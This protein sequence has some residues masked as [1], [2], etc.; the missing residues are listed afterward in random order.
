MSELRRDPVTGG[1]VI[2][3]PERARR[4]VAGRDTF[5]LGAG[6]ADPFAEGN[7]STTPPELFAFREP[8]TMADRPGW[9]VRIVPNK[10][11]AVRADEAPLSGEDDFYTSMTA[12]G[13]HEVIIECPDGKT[14]MAELSEVAIH[15]VLRA[16]RERL[17]AL[18]EDPHI[19]HGLIFKNSGAPAGASLPHSHSQLIA[20]S[21]VP[22][23]L[24]RELSRAQAYYS[25]HGESIYETII[26]REL[27]DEVRVVFDSPE[28][29]VFCPFA[30]RFPYETWI[31]PKRA[32]SHYE[33]CEQSELAKLA[34]VLKSV[35]V[36]LRHGL[37]DPPYNYILHTAPFNS[38]AL[39]HFRW[40]LEIFPRLSRL[41]GYEL[42]S[43][44]YINTVR[45][46]EAATLLRCQN[47]SADN[48]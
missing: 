48:C 2:L 19:A 44:F 28:F 27:S 3:A 5:P 31:L 38:S 43:G 26:S 14:T 4:P 17:L 11:P 46:D 12:Y 41:A 29:F 24:E 37:S 47:D 6:M 7:E 25:R 40:R 20:T 16:Y 22:I 10:Y 9:R 39:P 1:S 32:E 18:R 34:V 45:P 13:S 8:G 33:R 21:V 35:L 15:D 30:S 36:T 23:A 42:G